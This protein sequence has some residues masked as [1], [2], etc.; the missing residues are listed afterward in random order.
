MT[1]WVERMQQNRCDS[2]GRTALHRAAAVRDFQSVR[3]LILQGVDV[4]ARD[5][6]MRTPLHCASRS[7]C[8]VVLLLLS[9]GADPNAVDG[10]GRT[11]LHYSVSSGR[12]DIVR[13]L[14]EHGGDTRVRDLD[15]C[16]PA[17][18]AEPDDVDAVLQLLS[19]YRASPQARSDTKH[20]FSKGRT[21]K[22]K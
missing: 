22:T 18:Y 13:I 11:S 12:L 5:A 19:S 16:L 7:S 17:N 8:D 1:G 6:K 21:S 2:A 15:G 14:L 20:A 10:R 9:N 4:H 3:S